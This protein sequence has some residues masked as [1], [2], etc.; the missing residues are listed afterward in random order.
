[1]GFGH[2]HY[3]RLFSR[4]RFPGVRFQLRHLG[5]GQSLKYGMIIDGLLEPDGP[6]RGCSPEEAGGMVTE[7]CTSLTREERCSTGTHKKPAMD[8]DGA[9]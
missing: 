1:L 5:L 8:S 4:F 3:A 2:H 7:R 6:Q 9:L